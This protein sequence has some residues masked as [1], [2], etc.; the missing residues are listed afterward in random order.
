MSSVYG[1]GLGFLLGI[2][3]LWVIWS[4]RKQ[5][6]EEEARNYARLI[7][8]ID[9]CVS[10]LNRPCVSRPKQPRIPELRA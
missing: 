7:H 6:E 1:A 9:F 5:K 3:W 2:V 4:R 8:G 10:Q